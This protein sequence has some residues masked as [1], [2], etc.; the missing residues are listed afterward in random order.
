MER[1]QGDPEVVRKDLPR[2]RLY[3]IPEVTRQ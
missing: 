2:G 3:V 1:Y